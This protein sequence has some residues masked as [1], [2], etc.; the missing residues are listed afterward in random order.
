MRNRLIATYPILVFLVILGFSFAF[1]QGDQAA[2]QENTQPEEATTQAA[3]KVQLAQPAQQEEVKSEV[4]PQES[5]VEEQRAVVESLERSQNVTLDFKDADIRNVLKIISFKASVNIV[6]TPEVIGN[7]TIRLVDVPWE[8]ALDVI[9]K[10]YGFAYEKKGNIITVAPLEKLTTLKKQEA[11]LSQVQPTVT[12]VFQLR[13]IDAQDAKKAL[14]A[15][16]SGRGKITVLEFTGQAGWEFGA[17]ELGKRKRISEGR[18][19]R[20]KTLIV[21]DIPPALEKIKVVIQRIDIPPKQILIE[22]KLVEVNHDKL[23]EIGINWGTGTEGPTS[24]ITHRDVATYYVESTDDAGKLTQQAFKE[25]ITLPTVPLKSNASKALGAQFLPEVEIGE[26]IFQK[27]TGTKFE[28][29]LKALETN[30]DANI[31]SA[32]HILT[33]NNQEASILVGQKFPLLKSTVS[34]ETGSITGS[35]LDRYQDIGIQLNVVPQISG[36]NYI[37]LI[38]HPAVSSYTS[39]VQALSSTGQKMAEYPIIL[40]READ[41]QLLIKDG[42]TIVMGGL[43]K[44]EKSVDITGIPFLKDIPILGLL[45]QHRTTSVEKIDLLIFVTAKIIKEGDFS[46]EEIKKLEERVGRGASSNKKEAATIK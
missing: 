22:V 39:T 3:E 7:V 10:T 15:Q 28:A 37:N 25:I 19:S 42:E 33:L 32:P 45:F 21:S 23:R 5:P 31:L 38:L 14:E 40:T 36:D 13:Y 44:D 41:T 24:L 29:V 46:P 27:L 9:L 8:N 16:L 35:T 20:S 6:T 11:E 2:T 43:I 17:D 1:A 12:E 18:I 34:T 30:A 4:T 26:L